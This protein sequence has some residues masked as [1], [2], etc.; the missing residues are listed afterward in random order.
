MAQAQVHEVQSVGEK[1]ILTGVSDR[2]M[3]ARNW[4]MPWKMQ[5][6]MPSA[7]CPMKLAWLAWLAWQAKL[8][9]PLWTPLASVRRPSHL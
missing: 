9:R 3:K 6:L 1:S 5:K 7:C 2:H 8:R 4:S